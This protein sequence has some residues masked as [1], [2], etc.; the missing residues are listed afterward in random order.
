MLN[1]TL[2]MEN[3]I[4]TESISDPDEDWP[5][6]LAIVVLIAFVVVYLLGGCEAAR[7]SHRKRALL[8]AYRRRQRWK[9]ADV[10]RLRRLDVSDNAMRRIKRMANDKL[11]GRGRGVVDDFEHLGEGFEAEA[12]KVWALIGPTTPARERVRALRQT[13]L[14]PDVA[15]AL[16]RGEHALAKTAGQKSPA[17]A[18]EQ[19]V[20][21]CLGLSQ[22][23]VH[24]LCGKVRRNR[25]SSER[26][27]EPDPISVHEFE[28][29]SVT[30]GVPGAA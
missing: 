7:E 27:K 1:H 26:V 9:K 18:A 12:E 23:R 11:G 8:K 25:R 19:R 22:A 10:P 13:E 14:L 28:L 2:P 29:W 5:Q 15:E 21:A 20:A 6:S 17:E 30:G 3:S 16:Y 24:K 4:M